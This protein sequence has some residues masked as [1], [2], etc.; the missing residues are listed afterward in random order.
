VHILV[1][2][3]GKG[4]TFSV[5]EWFCED[6]AH[7]AVVCLDMRERERFIKLVKERRPDLAYRTRAWVGNIIGGLGYLHT[8]RGRSLHEICFDNLEAMLSMVTGT[9]VKDIHATVSTVTVKEIQ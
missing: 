3:R 5:V 1:G 7:R 9:P 8:M 2:D 4:K 6:T